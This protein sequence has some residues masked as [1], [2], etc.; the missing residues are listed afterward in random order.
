MMTPEETL[1]T[2]SAMYQ[3]EAKYLVSDYLSQS[4]STGSVSANGPLHMVDVECRSKMVAWCYQVVDFCKFQRETVSIAVNYLDRFMA[5][6]ASIAAKADRKIFQLVAMTCLY[7]AVKIHEPEAMDPK[8]VSTLSRGT[9]SPEE[10]ERMEATIL[11][12]LGWRM[13]PPTALAFVRL[14]LDL[15]PANLLGAAERE[16]VYE[17]SKFQT[18]LT[19]SEYDFLAV[20][21]SVVAYSALINAIESVGLNEKTMAQISYGLSE[22]VRIDMHAD[23]IFEVQNWLYQAVSTQP[24]KVVRQTP[25]VAPAKSSAARRSSFDVSPRSVAAQ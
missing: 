19:V 1:S 4:S 25:V 7:T 23:K 21:P 11:G 9:Y 8:L 18:E 16:T 15:L 10:V 5:T 17:L 22:T 3:Q 24:A 2:I 20:R 12:A 13:N 14:F 6:P